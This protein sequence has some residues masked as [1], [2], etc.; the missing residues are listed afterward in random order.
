MINLKVII[1][2]ILFSA[3]SA[4]S[5][6]KLYNFMVVEQKIILLI[7]VITNMPKYNTN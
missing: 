2:K 4:F 3:K 1:N 7:T 5:N 6:T